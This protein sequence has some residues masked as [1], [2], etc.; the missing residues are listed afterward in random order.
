MK[1]LL[2][3]G[4]VFMLLVSLP[5]ISCSEGNETVEPI[6]P[7]SPPEDVLII[8]GN[9]SDF[10]GVAANAMSTI[11]MALKDMVE[12]FNEENLIPG[13]RVEVIDYDNQYNPARN[14]PGYEL[15][16]HKGADLIWAATPGTAEILKPLAEKDEFV[17]ICATSS[18][19]QL[20]PPGY[21]FAFGN[22]PEYDAYTLLYWIAENDWDYETNG[23]AKIGGTAW[24]ES[25]SDAFLTSVEKYVEAHPEQFEFVSGDLTDFS[26]IW[27]SQIEKLKDC[28]Y[29]FPPTP[30][31]VFV[32]NYRAAGYEAKFIGA[33]AQDAF[34]GL[35]DDAELWEEIDGMLFIR[36]T[37]WWNEEGQIIDLVKQ[38]LHEKR[39]DKAEEIMRS[40]CGYL[41]AYQAYQIL[42]IIGEA[43]ET[44]GPENVG[45]QAIFEA[46]RSYTADVDGLDLY[47][48]SDTK[49]FSTNYYEVCKADAEVKNLVRIDPEW[50][51]IVREP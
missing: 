43:A 32:K 31:N 44:V 49:R 6:Q 4:I 51:P 36:A 40:G 46:T 28:D 9:I 21:L 27:D 3:V 45:S 34:M 22:V 47:G 13:I 41:S 25:Y 35:V 30:M 18:S 24:S 33:D 23:P 8:I 37:R 14:K 42:T 12:Y 38:V 39:P 16:K 11:T 48:F 17:V 20:E 19:E 29:L 2:I 7:E 50:I 10:T 15:L 26:F 1:Q 5:V